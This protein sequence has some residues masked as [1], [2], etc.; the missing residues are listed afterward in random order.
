[1]TNGACLSGE[2]TV[3]ATPCVQDLGG[4]CFR[5]VSLAVLAQAATENVAILA[6]DPLSRPGGGRE[7]WAEGGMNKTLE[8]LQ[9]IP[10]RPWNVKNTKPVGP[11]SLQPNTPLRQQLLNQ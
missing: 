9:R 7:G 11:F 6:L 4:R 3:S 5:P 8:T 2:R 10:A 1:M